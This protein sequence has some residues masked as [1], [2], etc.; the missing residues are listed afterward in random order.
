MGD[1]KRVYLLSESNIK[2]ED[3]LDSDIINNSTDWVKELKRKLKDVEFFNGAGAFNEYIEKFKGLIGIKNE[4]AIPL[5][6][7]VQG[8]KQITNVDE[9]IRT[10][11]LEGGNLAELAQ[12]I[13]GQ[14]TESEEIYKIID[15]TTKQIKALSPLVDLSEK[16]EQLIDELAQHEQEQEGL[17]IYIA[18]KK[19]RALMELREIESEKLKEKQFE[20]KKNSEKL[21]YLDEDLSRQERHY[22]E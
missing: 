11:V 5:M 3:I 20:I 15:D 7:R 4:N 10:H 21:S 9:M 19:S 13:I 1:I 17:S 14:F 6:F 16:R 8:T 12:D 2:L 18:K 22:I